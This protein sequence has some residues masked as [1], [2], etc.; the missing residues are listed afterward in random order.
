M[1]KKVFYVDNDNIIFY[2][3]F[4]FLY[5]VDFIAWYKSPGRG[6][7][8]FTQGE[9]VHFI[10]GLE[11]YSCKISPTRTGLCLAA[12]GIYTGKKKCIRVCR[13]EHG[14]GRI[15]SGSTIKMDFQEGA[16][17]I[18]RLFHGLHVAPS[19]QSRLQ[20]SDPQLL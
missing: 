15:F 12:Q 20:E 11:T 9:R 14:H 1:Q 8:S 19:C 5:S 13:F 17:W 4:A 18:T 2:N 6:T 10:I 7:L 16:G 3:L